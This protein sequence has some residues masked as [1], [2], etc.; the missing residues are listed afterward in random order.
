MPSA[1]RDHQHVLHS[2]SEITQMGLP[3]SP[4]VKILCFQCRGTSSIPGQG[5]KIPHALW[6]K[7]FLFKIFLKNNWKKKEITQMCIVSFFPTLYPNGVLV[8]HT[9]YMKKWTNLSVKLIAFWQIYLCNQCLDQ[10]KE[11]TCKRRK[12]E[13]IAFHPL[14][15]RLTCCSCWL[16]V[17]STSEEIKMI[18]GWST[19]CFR[20]KKLKW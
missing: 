16:T 10:Y 9:L 7:K 4:V 20:Q 11:K 8:I 18:M 6:P 15:Q 12:T 3:D 17:H 1:F 2:P 19:L 13:S 5:T 14:L